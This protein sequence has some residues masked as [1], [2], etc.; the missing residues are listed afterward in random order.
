MC[1]DA[2]NDTELLVILSYIYSSSTAI[3][4]NE[5]NIDFS[6][7]EYMRFIMALYST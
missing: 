3:D 7:L 2:K 5:V 1:L 6:M 4:T